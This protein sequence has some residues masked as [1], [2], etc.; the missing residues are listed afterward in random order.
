MDWPASQ[1][2]PPPYGM[3]WHIFLSAP[4]HTPSQLKVALLV[5]EAVSDTSDS[6][7][8]V[9]NLDSAPMCTDGACPALQLAA[10]EVV[11]DGPVDAIWIENMNTATASKRSVTVRILN[12]ERFPGAGRQQ[13]ALP[14]EWRAHQARSPAGARGQPGGGSPAGDSAARAQGSPRWLSALLRLPPTMTMLFEVADLKAPGPHRGRGA[15][16]SWGLCLQVA[17]PA[18]VSRCG[19]ARVP[20]CLSAVSLRVVMMSPKP[21]REALQADFR[22]ITAPARND[23]ARLRE[24]LLPGRLSPRLESCSSS[25]ESRGPRRCGAQ[26]TAPGEVTPSREELWGGPPSSSTAGLIW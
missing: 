17:S 25:V 19:M 8:W 15:S 12:P 7:K 4:S 2:L 6:K 10:C 20:R 23:A 3:L 1:T 26:F 18:T 21:L 13:N 14:R 22:L 24:P 11:F 5:R 16:A 9:G